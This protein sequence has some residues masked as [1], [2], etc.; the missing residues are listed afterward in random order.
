MRILAGL[1]GLI[2][3]TSALGAEVEGAFVSAPRTENHVIMRVVEIDDDLYGAALASHND[4]TTHVGR[5]WA[6]GKL[7][8]AT[9]ALTAEVPNDEP[10]K[11]TVTF[12]RRHR[13][14]VVKEDNCVYFHGVGTQFESRLVRQGP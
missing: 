3:A 6:T 13:A 11:L 2:V 1:A 14:A 7:T 9:L 5:V 8:G 10:C 12:L 4:K